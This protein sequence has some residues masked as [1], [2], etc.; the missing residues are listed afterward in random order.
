MKQ[1]Y[2]VHGL[3]DV[4]ALVRGHPNNALDAVHFETRRRL[5]QSFTQPQTE[6]DKVHGFA[7]APQHDGG[8]VPGVPVAVG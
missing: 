4:D 2:P 8:K 3:H 1:T 5:P 7:N 6:R